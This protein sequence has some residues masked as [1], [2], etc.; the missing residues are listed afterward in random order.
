MTGCLPFCASPG[1]GVTTFWA[2]A[3]S[4]ATGVIAMTCR[5]PCNH[6]IRCLLPLTFLILA[7]LFLP[8]S[9]AL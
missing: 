5:P 6:S 9:V 7:E 3:L 8:T 2:L 4:V 1:P